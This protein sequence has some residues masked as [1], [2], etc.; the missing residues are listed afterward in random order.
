ML[1]N[2]TVRELMEELEPL[3]KIT[4]SHRYDRLH[5]EMNKEQGCV[6]EVFV[7]Q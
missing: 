4:C 5:S 7:L 6:Y 1:K 2:L 3:T